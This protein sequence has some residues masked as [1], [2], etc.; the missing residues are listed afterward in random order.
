MNL[1]LNDLGKL[2]GAKVLNESRIEK[3]RFTGVSIDSRNCRI[4]DLFFAIKGERFDGHNFVKSVLRKGNPAAVVSKTWYK[5]LKASDKRSFKNKCLILVN[6]TIRSLGELACLYRKKFVLPVIGV[7]G[8]NGKTSTKDFIAHVL[9]KKYNVLKTEG[10]QNN[11]IGVP[12]TLFRLNQKHEIAVIELGTNHFGEIKYLCKI[13]QPQFGM[14]TNIGKEH[15]EFLK[16]IKGVARAEGE[17]ADHLKRINGTYFLNS[18]DKYLVKRADRKKMVVFSYGSRSKPDVKGKVKRFNKFYPEVEIKYKNKIINTKL[19]TIG[20]QSFYAALSAASIGFYFEVP[21]QKIKAA[22]SEY[23]IE[24]G[25]R[26]QLKL[27]KGI[28]FIDDTYNSNP[29]SVVLA[30]E[31][32]RNYRIKGNKYLV[33]ADMLELGRSGKQE[34]REIGRLVKKMKFDNLYTYGKESYQTYLGAKGVKNN[35]YFSDKD[36]LIEL[37]RLNIKKGDVIL[38]KGPRS[39]NMEEIVEQLAK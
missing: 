27:I 19:N 36:V 28:W 4:N 22:I 34:H 39:M 18:D 38:V 29:D 11:A 33:L 24:S 3:P 17:L 21:T 31:N 26:N 32:L 1:R 13:E 9:S 12:L 20:V 10:N 8:S 23:K 37:L 15:L 6:D 5:K 25:K 2:K 30:I 14:I 35:Y 7:C 16:D